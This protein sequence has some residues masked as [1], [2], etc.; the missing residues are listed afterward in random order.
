MD[1]SDFDIWNLIGL[2]RRQARLIIITV[3]AVIGATAAIVFTLTPIYQASALVLVD[4]TDKNLLDPNR[5][6]ASTSTD[7]ARLASELEIMQ[8]DAIMLKVIERE[9]LLSDDEFGVKLGM[10][11]RI[12]SFLQ[13]SQPSLPSGDMALRRILQQLKNA[14]SAGQVG[15][16][17]VISM[18][19]RSKSS[20]RAAE[21]ANA[22]SAAYIE[23]QVSAK[24]DSALN[25]RN[26]LQSRL[27]E[28]RSA[29]V[30]AEDGLDNYIDSNVGAI[31]G[32]TGRADIADVRTSLQQLL[33]QR[34]L[35][36]TRAE[37]AEASLAQKNWEQLTKSLQSVA[38]E[39]LNRQRAQLVATL[40]T[41]AAG[42][43]V[44]L[45]AELGD[46]EARLTDV[47]SKEVAG[48]R[49]S[50]SDSTSREASLR[51]RLRTAVLSSSLPANMLSQIYELQQGAELS[52]QQYQAL[53]AR[54]QDLD[55][56]ASLQIADSRVVSPAL[57]PDRASFPNTMFTMAAA[58]AAALALGLA[59]A[60]LREH[61]LGGILTEG[62]AEAVLRLPVAAAIPK[63]NL[64]Y[65]RSKQEGIASLMKEAPLTVFPESI[66]RIKVAIDQMIGRLSPRA[67]A[68]FKDRGVVVMVTSSTAGEGK[69][70][71]ALSLARS[72]ATTH[73][74][75][76]L[77]DCDFRKP[78]VLKMSGLP[79]NDGLERLL[80][81]ESDRLDDAG[82][83]ELTPGG[84]GLL[85]IA[86]SHPSRVPTDHVITSKPFVELVENARTNCDVVVLDT[87]PVG[88]VTD[89]LYLAGMAD[90]IVFVVR[91]GATS[92]TEAKAA[93]NSLRAATNAKTKIMV[94]LNQQAAASAQYK[95]RY[96]YYA[97]NAGD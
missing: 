40:E 92:Q 41:S 35:D 73:R 6:A 97:Y 28:A 88:P 69:S 29:L 19:V 72:F 48:L 78:S 51:E 12:T 60:F 8:S 82:Q 76:A 53:L 77:I 45:R 58:A 75:V 32:E 15:L 71:V 39:E 68:R 50:V 18:S 52:R 44:N 96:G 42:P 23:E 61:L 25:A 66:R 83:M 81:G 14:T 55:T 13:L 21:I 65:G 74:K 47:A 57:A 54:V 4:T 46:I 87:P 9:K 11:D 16:S 38:V 24:I 70:T 10:M 79:A 17:N 36:T 56:Q 30:V 86:T 3:I 90:V 63:T 5:G 37:Q 27:A 34:S 95:S 31:V 91:S 64:P 80:N 49:Q 85:T 93:V 26:V 1:E 2:L 94:V 22:W 33:S 89:G 84:G 7:S 62:Q 20:E 67:A 43:A 59:L